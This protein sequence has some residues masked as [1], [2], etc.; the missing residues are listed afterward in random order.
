MNPEKEI[1]SPQP[2]ADR[3]PVLSDSRD[4]IAPMDERTLTALKGSIEKWRK[5]EAGVGA[6]YGEDN[7]PLCAEFLASFINCSGCPV[8][9]RTGQQYCIGSPYKDTWLPLRVDWAETD[10]AK[11]AAS[12]EREFLESLLPEKS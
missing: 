5:I 11:A 3:E 4:Q 7:C 6:D 2:R 1:S 12:E 9:A 8:F 10:E